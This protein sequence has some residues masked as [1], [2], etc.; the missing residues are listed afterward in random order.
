MRKGN[1]SVFITTPFQNLPVR[2]EVK[3]KPFQQTIVSLR[4]ECRLTVFENRVLKKIFGPKRDE[5]TRQW[6][7]LHNKEVCA[8]YS[9]PNI[10]RLIKSGRVR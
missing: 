6:K 4:E 8:L 7:R 5:V 1:S 9:S 3:Y 2:C 10:I